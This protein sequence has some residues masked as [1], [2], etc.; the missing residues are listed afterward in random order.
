MINTQSTF[1][2][3]QKT[4]IEM[5]WDVGCM[6]VILYLNVHDVIINMKKM[7]NCRFLVLQVNNKVHNWLSH[8][9][10]TLTRI[11]MHNVCY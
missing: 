11:H 1:G 8:N 3:E 2:G 9:E 4:D 6:A 5:T 10:V 7:V